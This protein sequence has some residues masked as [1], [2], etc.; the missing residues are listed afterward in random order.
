MRTAAVPALLAL[1]I[2][3]FASTAQAKALV[4]CAD[5]SPEGFDPALW[6]SSSTAN[7]SSQMFQ[8]LLQ[9]E[10]GGTRLQPQLATQW[11]VNADATEFRFQ[12]RPRAR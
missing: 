9:F 5:A 12:L 6:D 2:A 1:L 11:S 4:Y 3:V 8:G 7:V 10:P